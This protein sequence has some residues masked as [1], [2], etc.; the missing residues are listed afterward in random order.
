VTLGDLMPYEAL[1]IY[2]ADEA[3]KEL[4]PVFASSPE[5]EEEIMND[6]PRFGQG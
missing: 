1:H 3:R 4:V 6:R 5:Y 2:E